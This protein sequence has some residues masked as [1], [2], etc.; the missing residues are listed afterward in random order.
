MLKK[1]TSYVTLLI[2]I[3]F[4]GQA[5]LY[6]LEIGD[7]KSRTIYIPFSKAIA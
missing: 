2:S 7:L 1:L 5:T 4:L 3:P 6:E